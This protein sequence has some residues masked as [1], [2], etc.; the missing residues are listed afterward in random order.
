MTV[1]RLVSAPLAASLLLHVVTATRRRR[2]LRA[3]RIRGA[4]HG[5]FTGTSA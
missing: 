4:I 1:T 2:A 5:H 3:G